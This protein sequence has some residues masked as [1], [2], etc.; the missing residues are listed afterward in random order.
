MAE[1]EKYVL[2][3]KEEKNELASTRGIYSDMR[4]YVETNIQNRKGD[5]RGGEGRGGVILNSTGEW[6]ATRQSK[7][8][9]SS[10]TSKKIVTKKKSVA[11]LSILFGSSEGGRGQEKQVKG[12]KIESDI[13]IIQNN[14]VCC[15][16]Q[17]LNWHQKLQQFRAPCSDIPPDDLTKQC[18]NE[19]EEL[20]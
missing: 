18:H 2:P 6:G 5:I 20:L 8:I 3:A 10:P 4:K 14:S 12:V 17:K 7:I 11:E 1:F 13:D 19:S 9:V 15:K 16:K